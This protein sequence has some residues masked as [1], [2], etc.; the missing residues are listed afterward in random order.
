VA[1]DWSGKAEGSR[2]A[3]DDPDHLFGPV[4]LSLCQ[5]DQLP[6]T[7]DQEALCRSVPGHSDAPPSAEL[8]EPLVPEHP[9]G[10]E[11]GIGVDPEHRGQ[12]PGRWKALAGT[13]LSLRYR[14]PDQARNLLVERRRA[15]GIDLDIEHSDSYSI[16][17]MQDGGSILVEVRPASG[18]S[19]DPAQALIEEA[20]R[21]HRRRRIWTA[22]VVAVVVVV[23]LVVAWVAGGFGGRTARGLPSPPG[24]AGAPSAPPAN[25]PVSTGTPVAI[26]QGPTDI[27]FLDRNHGW[28]ASGCNSF[29]YESNPHIIRTTNG[30]RTW[31]D[32]PPPNMAG[33][34]LSEPVW[35]QYGGVVK[36]RFTSATR[37]WYL[38]AGELWSTGDGGT[39]WSQAHLGGVVTTL[40]SSGN[41]MWALVDSCG[42]FPCA[43]FHLFYR[44]DPDTGWQRSTRT[45]SS[46]SGQ[47]SGS[48][49]GAFDHTAYIAVPGHTYSTTTTGPLRDVEASCNPV[50]SLAP[51]SLVG[52]CFGGD[53]ASANRFAIS[54]DDGHRW[55]PLVDGPPSAGWSGAIT[56]NG[57]GVLFYITGG[58]E[59]WRWDTTNRNWTEVLRTTPGSTDEMYPI[60]FT[61]ADTGF[62]GESGS[63]G[64]HLL[65]THDAG[66]TWAQVTPA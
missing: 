66:M 24:E 39:S 40:A 7:G 13:R 55:N 63:S 31:S 42:A 61:D 47:R 49:L 38:Q 29:C 36:V 35:H 32:V 6:C 23:G 59:L 56:T 11:D 2:Q 54:A 57:R 22:I 15:A 21:R 3:L 10:T 26:G 20:R 28:I 8:Q 50:G 1:G 37:G 48:W 17:M 62:V 25:A 12:V 27:H 46:G 30:G 16:T 45:L 64:V 41:Q 52:L 14:P 19:G 53:V 9:Q 4:A 5:I 60:Y 18:T 44:S 51:G 34:Y 65:E 33:T 58:A 43:S